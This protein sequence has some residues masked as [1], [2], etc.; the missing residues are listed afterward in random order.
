M[1]TSGLLIL[2]KPGGVTSRWVVDRVQ[3]LTRPAK[4]GH[5]GTLDPLATGVLVVAVGSATRLIEYVQ[6]M[7]KQYTGTFLLGR[8]S[9]TEDV[10]SEVTL[11]ADAIQPTAEQ[12]A[13][14]AASFVGQIQ[15]R[16]PAFSALKVA[17]RRAYDLARAGETPALAPRPIDIHAIEIR[18]YEYPEL[19]LEVTC[20]SGTYVRS[21]GRDLAQALGSDAVM[22]AL[23]RTAIGDFTL[24]RAIDPATLDRDTIARNLLSPLTALAEL[25]RVELT[26]V[27]VERVRRGLALHRD[28]PP[29]GPAATADSAPDSA[30]AD[31]A[32][33]GSAAPDS[34]AKEFAAIDAAGLLVAILE[35]RGDGD[36][37]PT[38]TFAAES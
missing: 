28:A 17:G 18:R 16:P 13:A 19:V 7:R 5:A 24:D 20:G 9:P 14:A 8:S 15:Q 30:S 3:R 26:A 11:L 4:V 38:R 31:S 10:E 35:S 21:L 22:S 12:V 2:N 23:N 6:R 36:L 32:A 27:E 33:A 37:R 1:P 29:A 25:P 34:A